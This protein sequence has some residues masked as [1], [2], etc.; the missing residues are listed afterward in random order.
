[1]EA[2]KPKSLPEIARIEIDTR[3][4]LYLVIRRNGRTKFW[5]LLLLLTRTVRIVNSQATGLSN[6]RSDVQK[7]CGIND[8][9]SAPQYCG[10]KPNQCA[11][12]E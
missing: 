9:A 11:E 4:L 10:E 2:K 12:A 1:M 6:S 5:R 8:A 7:K 3:V